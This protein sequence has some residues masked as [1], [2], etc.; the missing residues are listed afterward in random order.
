MQ[1]FPLNIYIVIFL[2]LIPK[3]HLFFWA[4]DRKVPLNRPTF[5]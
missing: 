3:Y 5:N 1:Q 4:L 2:E